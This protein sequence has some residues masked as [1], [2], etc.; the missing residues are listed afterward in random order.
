[1]GLN[2]TQALVA[3]STLHGGYGAVVSFCSYLYVLLSGCAIHADSDVA[4]EG[5]DMCYSILYVTLGV[6]TRIY[7]VYR[8]L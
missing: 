3:G 8:P 2:P 4:S 6:S 1:M 5:S 7:G